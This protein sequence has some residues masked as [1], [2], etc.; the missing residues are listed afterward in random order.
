MHQ[1]FKKLPVACAIAMTCNFASADAAVDTTGFHG[2]ARVGAG[3]SSAHG[4]QSCFGLGGNTMKYRLGNECDA[5]L[6]GGYTNDFATVD[7]VTYTEIGRA[8]V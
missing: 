2:Y 6:E 7:G 3:T 4:P 8:H 1:I 5:Y